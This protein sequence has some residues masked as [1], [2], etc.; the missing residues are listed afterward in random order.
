MNQFVSR[1][2]TRRASLLTLGAAGLKAAAFP[3]AASAKKKHGKKKNE[4]A[5]ALCKRQ[6][7]SCTTFFNAASAGNPAFLAR[8]AQCCPLLGTCQLA[9]TFACL[10]APFS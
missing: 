9:E 4:D 10:S 3:T 2:L 8:V 1:A 5:N 6:I 7:A